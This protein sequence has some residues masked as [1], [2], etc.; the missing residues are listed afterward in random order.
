MGSIEY[1]LVGICE[2]RKFKSL[3]ID[4]CLRV[5]LGKMYIHLE[6]PTR[7][8]TDL[9]VSCVCGEEIV[10]SH[11]YES[12]VSNGV[13][14]IR[15][16]TSEIVKIQT[17]ND[18]DILFPTF[19][20]VILPKKLSKSLKNAF[21]IGSIKYGLVGI[22]ENRYA[23]WTVHLD[24]TVFKKEMLYAQCVRGHIHIVPGVEKKLRLLLDSGPKVVRM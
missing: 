9:Y 13:L 18:Y 17:I 4:D 24:F 10:R 11:V 14:K 1:G 7:I 2:N 3:K 21:I 6:K 8:L 5:I 20:A 15:D 16:F 23:C 12:Y 19:G 22:S